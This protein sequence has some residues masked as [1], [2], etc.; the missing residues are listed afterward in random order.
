[1]NSIYVLKHIPA[2]IKRLIYVYLI[3]LGTPTSKLI[4]EEYDKLY[5]T[6]K[7][8][9]I[10]NEHMSSYIDKDIG[11]MGCKMCIKLFFQ[12]TVLAELYKHYKGDIRGKINEDWLLPQHIYEIDGAKLF[13][14]YN[15]SNAY[16]FPIMLSLRSDNNSLE[17]LIKY[18]V[19]QLE[20]EEKTIISPSFISSYN[21]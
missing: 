11:F 10:V 18:K 2:S 19:L 8:N 4:K 12:R 20:I 5:E 9:I 7:H 13:Y 16:K 1:M 6:N 21:Y 14:L 3:G 17:K 15:W